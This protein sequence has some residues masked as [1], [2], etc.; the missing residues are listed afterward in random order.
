MQLQREDIDRL[1]QQVHAYSFGFH[2]AR[3][4]AGPMDE[5]D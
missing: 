2:S 1:Q 3:S 5:L 4:F